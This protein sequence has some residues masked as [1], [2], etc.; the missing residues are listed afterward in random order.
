MR[1][2]NETPTFFFGGLDFG[3]GQEGESFFSM[4]LSKKTKRCLHLHNTRKLRRRREDDAV[5]AAR[6]RRCLVPSLRCFARNDEH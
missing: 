5:L 4:P 6:H 2:K 1:S 3:E